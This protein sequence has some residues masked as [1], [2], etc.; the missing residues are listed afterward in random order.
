MLVTIYCP[1]CPPHYRKRPPH[2]QDGQ[3]LVVVEQNVGGY[4]VDHYECPQC[5][6]LFQVTYK[7]DEVTEVHVE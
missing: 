4:D 2:E 1:K 7:V 3:L 6:L 5:Q